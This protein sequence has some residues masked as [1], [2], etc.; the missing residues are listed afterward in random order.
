MTFKKIISLS[1]LDKKEIKHNATGDGPQGCL[2]GSCP[3]IY[4]TD[5]GDFIFQGFTLG[6]ADKNKLN[7]AEN[8]DAVF[9][10]K[11]LIDNFRG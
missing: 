1:E 5:A 11:E 7:L 6:Q 2:T 3:T 9:I 4:V 8:E 10:P